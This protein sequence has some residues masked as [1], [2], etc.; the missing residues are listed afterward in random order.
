MACR[1]RRGLHLPQCAPLCQGRGRAPSA[2]RRRRSRSRRLSRPTLRLRALRPRLHRGAGGPRHPLVRPAGG[3][4]HT[5]GQLLHAGDGGRGRHRHHRQPQ[6]VDRQ[7]LQ[8]QGRHRRRGGAGDARCDGSDDGHPSGGRAAPAARVRRCGRGRAGGDVRPVS[9]LPGPARRHRRHRAHPRRRQARA[10]R[11]PLRVGGGLVHP[12]AGGRPPHRPRAAYRAQPLLRRCEPGADPSQRRRV[13]GG[14][15]ALGRGHRDRLR[16][17]RRSGRHGDGGGRLRQ[18]APGLRPAV[19]VPARHPR[20]GGSGGLHR[21]DHQHGEAPCRDLRHAGLRDGRRVQVRRPEDDR[22]QRRHRRRGVRRLRVRH[23]HSG[24]G[25]ARLGPLPARPVADEGQARLRG[26]R[27]A[28]GP[29]RSVLLRPDRH[30]LCTRGLR[31]RQGA[32]AGGAGRR[33]T[34]LARGPG[35]RG[36][37]GP[38]HERRLQVPSRRRLVAADP[39]QRHGGAAAGLRRGAITRGRGGA[40]GEGRRLAAAEVAGTARAG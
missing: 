11:E 36:A 14:D 23:A 37:P 24:A 10:G 25:R 40:P 15:P 6:P 29:G 22:D 31:R 35:R 7:R 12:A 28:A 16:R 4:T 39:L 3:G 26:A 19:L 9:P 21:H 13:A 20:S 33:G 38:K 8:G 32:E 5:G 18:P 34:D 30:P 17:R 1:H 2:D 27:R